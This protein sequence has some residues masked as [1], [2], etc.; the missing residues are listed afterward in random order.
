MIICKNGRRR[1][2][3]LDSLYLST[4]SLS[5]NGRTNEIFKRE[6]VILCEANVPIFSSN[7][8]QFSYAHTH[9]SARAHTYR[10]QII[11]YNCRLNG[12]TM[13]YTSVQQALSA[14][15]KGRTVATVRHH[16]PTFETHVALA[17]IGSVVPVPSQS[18]VK[19]RRGQRKLEEPLVA[20]ISVD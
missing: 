10:L 3:Q 7:L 16:L 4:W 2:W 18:Q 8:Q 20:L 9:T 12:I 11:Y 13:R 15:F 14:I 5:L 6:V 17:Q 19:N 1:T